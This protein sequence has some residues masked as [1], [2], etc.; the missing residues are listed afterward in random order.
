MIINLCNLEIEIPEVRLGVSIS[1]GADSAIL[2]YILMKYSPYPLYFFTTAIKD[3]QF[4]TVK[5]SIDII[6]KCMQLT[7]RADVF[8]TIEYV[9]TNIRENFFSSLEN[10]VNSGLV[11]IVCTATTNVP[12]VKILN[13]FKNKLNYDILLRRNPL[14]NKS[15]YSHNNKMYHPFFNLDKKMIHNFYLELNVLDNL[16]PLTRSC[17]SLEIFDKHCGGCWWCEERA[18]AFG[19]L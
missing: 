19:T 11:N 16:F 8:H 6:Q 15:L 10:K 1:G 2:T 13:E 4:I 12:S 3:K 17:E 5:H 14:K 7:G 18:W 9:E